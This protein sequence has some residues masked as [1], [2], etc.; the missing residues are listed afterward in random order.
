MR[1]TLRFRRSG[2]RFCRET[3][4]YGRPDW[5]PPSGAGMPQ[6]VTA[7]AEKI[8]VLLVGPKKPVI[9]D[10]LAPAF[11]LHILA[12][13]KDKEA[14]MAGLADRIRGVRGQ[15]VQRA[16]RRP[17]DVAFPKLEIVS[18]FAVGYDHVDANGP[19][20]TASSSPTRPAC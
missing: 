16:H 19:A 12:D 13:A 20:S 17:I 2:L 5:M 9:V 11:N 14:F 7:M 6:G 3:A 8:D 15:R 18:T 4:G 1:V 10:G